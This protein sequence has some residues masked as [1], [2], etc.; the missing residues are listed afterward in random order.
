MAKLT[1]GCPGRTGALH[2]SEVLELHQE[3][4]AAL[5]EQMSQAEAVEQALDLA[6]RLAELKD[7][8]HLFL[9]LLALFFKETMTSILCHRALSADHVLAA[10]EGWNLPQ[11]SAMVSAVEA[12]RSDLARNCSR[13]VVCEVLLLDLFCGRET[14]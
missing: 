1:G 14:Q 11:L 6:Q 5:K 3:C 4:L 10:R 9:D 7:E 2:S 12:A 13:A 8:L